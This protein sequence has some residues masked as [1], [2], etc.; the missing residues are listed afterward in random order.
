MKT[1]LLTLVICVA[2][3]IG[4]RPTLRAQEGAPNPASP[5]PDAAQQE[6]LQRAL[7]RAAALRTNIT[8]PGQIV[9]FRSFTTN[10]ALGDSGPSL[11]TSPRQTSPLRT[12]S[13]VVPSDSPG[14]LG[15]AAT[16]AAAQAAALA[17]TPGEQLIPIV[18]PPGTTN[19]A[20]EDTIPAG[21]IN[22]R[23]V[24]VD[25]VLELY[26]ELVNR[27]ILRPSS[28][29]K[30]DIVLRTQTPLTRRE[31]IQALATVLGMN[32][33]Y[34][35]EIGDKFAKAVGPPDA[36]TAGQGFNTNRSERLPDF[37]PYITHVTQLKY[38]K[39]SEMVQVLQPFAKSANAVFP[40]DSSQILVLRDFTENV[41]RMLQLISEVD[42]V[43]PSEFVSEVIP[44]KYALSSDI[45]SALNSL[46][47]TGG[48]STSVGTRGT[49]GTRTSGG[50]GFGGR[51]GMGGL[52]GA[53][54]GYPGQQ[55]QFGVNPGMNQQAATTPGAQGGN[56]SDRLRNIINRASSAGDI[57][58]IGQTKIIADERTNSLLIFA[59][60]EDMKTIKDIVSKLDIV[61]A[62]VLIEAVII[63]VQLGN[64]LSLGVSYLEK[65]QHGIGDYFSGIGAFN[66]GNGL[67]LNNFAGAGTN[68]GGNPPGGFSYLASL[69]GDLDISVTALADN[70]RARILQ[71]PRIQTS[72]AKQASLFVGQS[73]P[74]PTA[75]YY[76]GGAYGGYSSIQQMQ[77]GVSIDVTPLINPDGLVV[78]D[79]HQ[80]IED[81]AG[82]VNIVN[83]GDIPITSSKE[84]Q[85]SVAVR[86]RDTIIL[87]GLINNNN[88]TSASGV[89]YLKDIPL[90]GY[91]FRSSTRKDTRSE[92]IVLIRPTVLPTP[93][94]A[95]LTA[96]AEKD[97][98]PGIS[99]ADKEIREEEAKRL[100]DWE[101][102]NRR[103][104]STP[105]DERRSKP[106]F[107]THFAPVEPQ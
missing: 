30:V 82:T 8:V 98:M 17:A 81:V 91:L 87:G 31:A 42:V 32:G 72:N 38:A 74:Y 95:A 101:K 33:I 20:P 51:G 6:S 40:I 64:D 12:N 68:A 1:K 47:G 43:V 105:S 37:G 49:T 96:T 79:I 29:P 56:F 88:S 89:P 85:A 102:I 73:R 21:T 59:T 35:I 76:G 36:M 19:S 24:D 58:V 2:G 48:G 41:K 16:N 52:G 99:R 5:G 25:K 3:S 77:I 65:K 62:Q 94:V 61:L 103:G 55:N 90:L 106:S 69:G 107:D 78:M 93:E 57:Q 97:R 27:T 18:P 10:A 92:L 9:P 100:K 28:L 44:I 34:I 39:P 60:R 54:T 84:A 22:F 63:E 67:S 50:F 71:R 11:R 23:A 86:D 26:A 70:S 46:S 104:R 15:P 13:I 66:N 4:L 83:V 53:G 75:S 7:Q 45:A 80:K 14:I